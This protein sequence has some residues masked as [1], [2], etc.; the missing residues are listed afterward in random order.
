MAAYAVLASLSVVE[1]CN[2]LIELWWAL[3]A[4]DYSLSKGSSGQHAGRTM[5]PFADLVS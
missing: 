4:P 3:M 1:R 5:H 2:L